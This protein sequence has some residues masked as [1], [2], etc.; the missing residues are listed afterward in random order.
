MGAKHR[1]P[2]RQAG[3]IALLVLVSA[4]C[5]G[6]DDEPPTAM[7]SVPAC[8]DVEAGVSRIDLGER[9]Y[10][11]H[12]PPAGDGGATALPLVIDLHGYSEGATLHAE[13]TALGLLGEREGFVTVTPH[14]LGDPPAW[15]LAPDGIDVAF[16]T[17]VLDDVAE[18]VCIDADRVFVTGHS[19]GGFL[20]SSLACTD[21]TTRIAAFASVAGVR[22][23]EACDPPRAV[24]AL[25]VHG[26]DDGVVLYDGGLDAVA[27]DLLELPVEG[28]SIPAIV[29]DW[30]A[31]DPAVDVELHTIEGGDHDW[32][33]GISERVWRFFERHPMG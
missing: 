9:W 30:A 7:P 19:M 12:V 21:L 33:D 6:G 10:L 26:T 15:D 2:A 24:P 1:V 3:L 29:D 25:V 4:A 13:R 11:R 22:D 31:R 17:D 28:P 27:A 5:A 14:A 16:V 18:D 32:P 20:I 8:P 23:V